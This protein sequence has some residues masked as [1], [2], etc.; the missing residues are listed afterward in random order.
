MNSPIG[1]HHT[2]RV[3]LVSEMGEKFVEFGLDGALQ[4]GKQKSQNRR[5]AERAIPSEKT[6]LEMGAI[7]QFL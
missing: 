4:P 6:S 2:H 1:R 5:E 3:R 7:K